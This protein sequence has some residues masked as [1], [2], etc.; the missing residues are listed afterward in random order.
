MCT[1]CTEGNPHT[2][3]RN[4]H[5]RPRSPAHE[6][7]GSAHVLNAKPLAFE[8]YRANNTKHGM[9]YVTI[10]VLDWKGKTS[11]SFQYRTRLKK[12]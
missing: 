11:A 3:T 5:P 10:E 6:L 1:Q 8:K 7:K 12:P 2:N 9:V 4:M